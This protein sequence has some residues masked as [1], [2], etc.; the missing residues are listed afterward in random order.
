VYG[1]WHLRGAKTLTSKTHKIL[2]PWRLAPQKSHEIFVDRQAQKSAKIPSALNRFIN[3]FDFGNKAA[4]PP[5]FAVLKG[6]Q[7]RNKSK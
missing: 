1:V 7:M 2:S 6:V 4:F 3:I 5:A